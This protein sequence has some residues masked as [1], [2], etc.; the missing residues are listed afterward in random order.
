MLVSQLPKEDIN[1]LNDEKSKESH[2]NYEIERQ[3][4]TE[5]ISTFSDVYTGI[6]IAAP[7]FFIAAL[8]LISILGGGI[9]GIPVDV[10]IALGTYLVIPLLNVMSIVFIEVSQPEA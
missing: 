10:I 8:S 1:V 2:L 6:L 4:Y 9:G 5:T 7:L 3:K